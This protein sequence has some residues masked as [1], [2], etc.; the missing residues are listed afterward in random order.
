[1]RRSIELFEELLSENKDSEAIRYE[2][3]LTL[4]STEAFG[5]NQ[6]LRA[7]RANDLSTALLA[8]SPTIPRYQALKAHTL[9]TLASHQ[10]RIGR[11]DAAETSLV[12]VLRIYDS[13]IKDSPE[14]SLYETRRSR[15]LESMADVKLRQGDSKA[16]IENLEQAIRRLQ[17]RLRLPD[18]S[19]VARMQLQRMKQ[20]LSRIKENP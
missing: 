13:L 2:L 12:E 17:P 9:E 16:A 7:V 18:A 4:S 20:K 10:Q 11:L 1:M 3:A 5:I 19:P 14:L 6:M 8:N 15:V